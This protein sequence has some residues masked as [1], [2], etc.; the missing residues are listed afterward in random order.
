MKI[1]IYIL[2]CGLFS[3]CSINKPHND[4]QYFNYVT[5]NLSTSS[6]YISIKVNV[7]DSLLNIVIK[8][9]DFYYIL[10]TY[11]FV[12]TEDEYKQIVRNSFKESKPFIINKELA[13]QIRLRDYEVVVD[14]SLNSLLALNKIEILT[15]YFVNGVMKSTEV[16]FTEQK[17]II[18]Y[19]FKHGIP[20]HQ[21]CSSG[22][23][24]IKDTVFN[25]ICK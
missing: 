20:C 2:L 15:K 5:E 9:N 25:T 7:N 14:S 16:S 22:S 17:R 6:N 10:A 3:S 23:I 12:K 18:Y 8:N 13:N 11:S 1:G 19:L 24:I 4:C 21:D